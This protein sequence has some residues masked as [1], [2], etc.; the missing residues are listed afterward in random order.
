MVWNPGTV[1]VGLAPIDGCGNLSWQSDSEEWTKV[2]LVEQWSAIETTNQVEV[3]WG[4]FFLL[5]DKFQFGLLF[6]VEYGL[7]KLINIRYVDVG[8]LTE[9]PCP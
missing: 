2:V 9:P 3:P 5:L 7:D 4:L 8:A 1:A 6:M